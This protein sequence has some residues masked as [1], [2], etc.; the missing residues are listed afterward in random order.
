MFDLPE[1]ITIW[2]RTGNDG[3]GGTTWATPEEW[4]A[5]IA[6]S[7]QK[8]TD[9]N[10]DDATSTAVCYTRASISETELRAGVLV[11]LGT[12]SGAVSP[13][14]EAKDVRARSQTPTGPGALSKLWF[15]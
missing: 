14:A 13:P 7:Q 9:I 12:A 15:A 8:F 4:P 10:G 11:L 3:F 5:R 6:Y 2:R 1:T